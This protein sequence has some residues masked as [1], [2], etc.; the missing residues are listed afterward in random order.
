M[1]S[2]PR[3]RLRT[4]LTLVS[5]PP[6]YVTLVPPHAYGVSTSS[7]INCSILVFHTLAQPTQAI[8]VLDDLDGRQAAVGI[9]VGVKGVE[10]DPKAAAHAQ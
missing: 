4:I 3:Q 6:A 2:A 5:P 9:E 10:I 1:V 8:S 7:Y